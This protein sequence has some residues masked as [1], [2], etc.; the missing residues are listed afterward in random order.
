MERKPCNAA[1]LDVVSARL[2]RP[3]KQYPSRVVLYQPS[4]Q[5]LEVFTFRIDRGNILGPTL[6]YPRSATPLTAGAT[7]CYRPVRGGEG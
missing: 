6:R 7:I 3:G 1:F 4:V 2:V 5:N